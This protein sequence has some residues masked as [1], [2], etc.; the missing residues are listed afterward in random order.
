MGFYPDMVPSKRGQSPPNKT[1]AYLWSTTAFKTKKGAWMANAYILTAG[2]KF[3]KVVVFP[4]T[5][6][7]KKHEWYFLHLTEPRGGGY[8]LENM[9]SVE[10]YENQHGT[11]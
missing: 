9:I 6:A 7:R 2:G 11:P 1:A 4:Q 3:E 5:Y 10:A 8:A